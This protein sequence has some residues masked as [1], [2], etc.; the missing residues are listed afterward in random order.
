MEEIEEGVARAI[1]TNHRRELEAVDGAL[2][3][4]LRGYEEFRSRKRKSDDCLETARLLLVIRSFNSLRTARQ[5]LERGYYQQAMALVRMAM[6]DQLVAED[7]EI[8]PPTMV[9]L[10]D[11]EGKLGKG[12]LALSEMAS[13]LSPKARA[14]WDSD[15]GDASEYGAHPRH[16]SLQGLIS[17][18]Q[19]EQLTV[20]P[21]SSYNKAEVNFVL[22]HVLR[23]LV[24][25]MATTCKIT[26]QV[27]SNWC[28]AVKP[29]F[30][31]VMFL[32][33]QLV[34]RVREEPEESSETAD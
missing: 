29:V 24:Y 15:Y 13:R 2:E 14:A 1:Q 8:Y 6:E 11:G 4:I 7:A 27:G 25:V 12:T 18:D 20:M 28:D 30:E 32:W 3:Q 16:K 26:H 19:Y 17:W 33:Q 9:A 10:L 23:S 21:G 31:E 22:Y 34:E 5:T